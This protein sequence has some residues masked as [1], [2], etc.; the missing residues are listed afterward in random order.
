MAKDD[1][2]RGKK[3]KTQQFTPT[4][5]PN[6]ILRAHFRMILWNGDLKHILYVVFV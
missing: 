6:E 5:G 4:K 2:L 1:W 3:K